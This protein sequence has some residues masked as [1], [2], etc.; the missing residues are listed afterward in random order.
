MVTPG[1]LAVRGGC[2]AAL[3]PVSDHAAVS[4]DS[5][6]LASHRALRARAVPGYRMAISLA[7]T[8]EADII[9]EPAPG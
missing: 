6:I 2:S 4:I 7:P 8:S 9:V 3:P 5:R 1:F